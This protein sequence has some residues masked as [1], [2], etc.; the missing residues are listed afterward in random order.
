MVSPGLPS[1]DTG[2]TVNLYG[3]SCATTGTTQIR[4][5]DRKITAFI[6]EPFSSIQ[7]DSGFE[8]ITFSS[9][10]NE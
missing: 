2:E 5:N 4:R 6:H 7:H 1:A 3:T 8:L 10:K 9:Q